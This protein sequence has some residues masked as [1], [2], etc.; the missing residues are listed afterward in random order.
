MLEPAGCSGRGGEWKLT[1]GT[2]V[3]GEVGE[4]S[5]GGRTLFPS[6]TECAEMDGVVGEEVG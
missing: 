2:N 6:A 3:G 5:K 4:V 1:I